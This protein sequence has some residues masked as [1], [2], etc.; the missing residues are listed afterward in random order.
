MFRNTQ[1]WRGTI[2]LAGATFVSYLLGFLRD[3]LFAQ[4]FGA[5]PEL[6]A[7][8]AAFIIPDLILNIF[9]AGAL[10]AAFV[11]VFSELVAKKDANN[12]E[13]TTNSVLNGALGT[14]LVVGAV[15]AVMAPWLSSL[16]APGFDQATHQLHI[17]LLRILLISP[18]LF[19]ASNTLGSVLLTDKRFWL[20]GL[21]PALYNLGIVCG[22]LFLAPYWGIYG[23]AFGTL[24]GAL[25]H[26]ILRLGAFRRHRIRYRPR[27]AVSP[28]FKKIV[29]LMI[30]KMFGHPV[31]QLTFLGFTAIASTLGT[32]SIVVLNFA[33]NFQSVPISVIGIA[34][35][36]AIFPHLSEMSAVRDGPSFRRELMHAIKYVLLVTVASAVAMYLLR[37][38]L[39]GLL[40][41]GGK[42]T[43]ETA[44]RTAQTLGVFTLAIPTESLIHVLVRAFYALNNT[45]IPVTLSIAGFCIA[46]PVAYFLSPF[47]GVLALP[48]GF[49]SGS[50]VEAL[51]L[52][53][54]LYRREIHRFFEKRI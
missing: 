24:T 23:V 28:P 25:A 22:A 9:V 30:P 17:R 19:A 36:L 38:W 37:D 16:I 32:G 45:F 18:L 40:L 21:S 41:G 26:L 27:I 50:F 31:E 15:A 29:R 20:Y 51:L 6:D 3:R 46:I 35:G 43:P 48:F 54:I 44:R 2:I 33:R 5:S 39:I 10:S 34:M 13:E 14:V 8:N 49:F 52:A 42:F 47:Y 11:P 53:G 1:F 7:Y 12:L 4:R